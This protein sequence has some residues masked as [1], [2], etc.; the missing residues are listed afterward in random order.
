MSVDVGPVTLEVIRNRLVAIT[1]EMR[2]A[3]QSVSGSPTVYSRTTARLLQ[4]DSRLRFM[5]QY[6]ARSSGIFRNALG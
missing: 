4:W 2:V 1:E 6:P 3:L 5:R